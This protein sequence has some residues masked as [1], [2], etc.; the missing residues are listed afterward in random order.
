MRR[1]AAELLHKYVPSIVKMSLSHHGLGT[2]LRM[3]DY[4]RNCPLL[5]SWRGLT[6]RKNYLNPAL[7][8]G[9]IEMTIPDKPNS[10]NQ[11]YRRKQLDRWPTK[12]SDQ[13]TD[14]VNGILCWDLDH[15]PLELRR[16][17]RDDGF[18]PTRRIIGRKTRGP[19]LA[20]RRKCVRNPDIQALVPHWVGALMS[21]KDT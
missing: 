14:Q 20:N 18:P 12:I 21:R 2:F 13:D 5:K 11:R 8:Q 19:V 10:R 4:T 16:A 15:K 9:V 1:K 6:F 17:G 7:A 3:R